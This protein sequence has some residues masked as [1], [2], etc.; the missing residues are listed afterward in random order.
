MTSN[1][2]CITHSSSEKASRMSATD[3][4]VARSAV[5][6]QL[7]A[8]AALSRQSKCVPTYVKGKILD[9]DSII[10]NFNFFIF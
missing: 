3:L 2:S 1:N 8:L 9:L 7:S 10:Y 6:R 4:D 5:E